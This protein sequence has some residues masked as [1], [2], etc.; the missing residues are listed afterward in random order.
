M[1]RFEGLF[2]DLQVVELNTR[3]EHAYTIPRLL[4][5]FSTL[6]SAASVFLLAGCGILQSELSSIDGRE[7][8]H[9]VLQP[10]L[11]QG[12]ALLKVEHLRIKQYV[13]M[14]AR[15]GSG[16]GNSNFSRRT[17]TDGT[18]MGRSATDG[19]ARRSKRADWYMS[20]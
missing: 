20:G 15:S 10:A 17:Q 16:G 3:C 12:Y 13:C 19:V 9:K 11:L 7:G 18:K 4:F 5:P 6:R 8:R 1:F 2:L 14:A